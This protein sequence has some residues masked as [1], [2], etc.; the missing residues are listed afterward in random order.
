VLETIDEVTMGTY[1]AH[2]LPKRALLPTIYH[3]AG[4]APDYARI[5]NVVAG[6]CIVCGALE[7]A[8]H[9]EVFK[10]QRLDVSRVTRVSVYADHYELTMCP[11]APVK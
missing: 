11:E 6:V 8:H 3:E 5:A 7:C 1:A 9:Y 2:E 4:V 10:P